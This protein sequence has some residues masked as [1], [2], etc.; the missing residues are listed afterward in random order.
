MKE[1]QK[2]SNYETESEDE[3]NGDVERVT[4]MK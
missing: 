1:R 4:D 3:L 2:N